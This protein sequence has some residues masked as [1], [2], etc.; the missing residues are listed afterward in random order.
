MKTYTIDPSNTP[1]DFIHFYNTLISPNITKEYT[2]F[3]LDICRIFMN[4]LDNDEEYFMVKTG[5]VL[6]KN[7][8]CE[9]DLIGSTM[10][11]SLT[12]TDMSCAIYSKEFAR[13]YLNNVD[14]RQHHDVIVC[15]IFPSYKK[16]PVAIN[17]L[18]LQGIEKYGDIK[19]SVNAH[20]FVRGYQGTSFKFIDILEDFERMKVMKKAVETKFFETWGL[21]ISIKDYKYIKTEFE[22]MA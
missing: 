10:V 2:A 21:P 16:N 15:S 20:N 3:Y 9:D 1:D 5:D 12:G 17:P 8:F 18:P 14:T 19:W 4:A 22:K 11:E 13:I 6:F 7:D